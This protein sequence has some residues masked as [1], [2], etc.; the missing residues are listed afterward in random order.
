MVCSISTG[1]NLQGVLPDANTYTDA[2]T[3]TYAGTGYE[4]CIFHD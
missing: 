1:L 2:D 3:N 4:R